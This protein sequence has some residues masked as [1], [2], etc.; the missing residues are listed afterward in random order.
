ME[1]DGELWREGNDNGWDLN[2]ATR[3]QCSADAVGS[4]GVLGK[5]TDS[6]KATD[7]LLSEKLGC[8]CSTT[9]SQTRLSLEGSVAGHKQ[10]HYY[11]VWQIEPRV[12]VGH[13]VGIDQ[14]FLLRWP[15]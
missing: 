3:R 1:R 7:C 14:G 15:K 10:D 12:G 11:H 4:L 6:L 8:I 2:T 13:T 9:V 5:Y